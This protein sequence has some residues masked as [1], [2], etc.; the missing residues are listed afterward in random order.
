MNHPKVIF[1]DPLA[2]M[3]AC[4]LCCSLIWW[5]FSLVKSLTGR[6]W[7]CLPIAFVLKPLV[8]PM[9]DSSDGLIQVTGWG[10]LFFVTVVVT[11]WVIIPMVKIDNEA[12]RAVGLKWY[13]LDRDHKV[14]AYLHPTEEDWEHSA[15]V[16]LHHLGGACIVWDVYRGRG[17]MLVIRR[18]LLEDSAGKLVPLD[19]AD[20]I[21]TEGMRV[22]AYR[23]SEAPGHYV[24]ALPSGTVISA[25]SRTYEPEP[26][27]TPPQAPL[28]A[29]PERTPSRL[30]QAALVLVLAFLLAA[31]AV[32]VVTMAQQML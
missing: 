17:D 29:Q 7:L 28:P 14:E 10:C 26:E 22:L 3:L 16:A 20:R 5:I 18:L 4:I 31:I 32:V 30:G 27:P 25:P 2:L 1:V 6:R 11:K 13:Q 15:L 12:R 21:C 9:L 24:L 19:G 23:N 8:Q